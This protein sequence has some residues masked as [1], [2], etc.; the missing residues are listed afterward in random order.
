MENY[1]KQAQ[2]YYGKAPLIVLGSGSSAAHGISGM[3]ALAEHLIA[4]VSIEGLDLVDLKAWA[5]FK[6]LLTSGR[7]LEAALHSVNLS[8][9]LNCKIIHAT[10][11]LISR[12]DR[13]VFNE[14]IRGNLRL[15]LGTLL[16]HMFKTSLT[17]IEIIT[18][19]YDR[20]A[21]YA[22]EQERTHHYSGFTQGF[23]RHISTPRELK[24]N[25]QV[26]IWKV[27]GSLDWFSSPQ[28]NVLGLANI[29]HIPEDHE[30]QI[31]T[32]GVQKYLQ[33]HRE[34]FRSIISSADAA[35]ASARSYLCVG[36]GFNDEHIQPKLIQK[37]RIEKTPITVIARTLT[38]SARKYI[39]GVPICQNYMAIERGSIDE[40]SI[41]YSSLFPSNPLTIQKNLW[42]LN[43]YLT[44]IM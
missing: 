32:P 16:K 43:G 29:E 3:R 36:Y 42:S 28:H 7:D 17:A 38:D 22:C 1:E 39:L 21:E 19:N 6:E 24:A 23:L 8:E 4:T 15:P 25:R 9:D 33:T 2:D 5:K 35:L 44:L 30:P 11:K 13:R 14:L 12:E 37:C 26:N 27:H 31:V 34:P 18:T 41:V 10:W 40:E 20:I